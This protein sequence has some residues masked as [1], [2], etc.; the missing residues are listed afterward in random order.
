[1]DEE[2]ALYKKALEIYGI[3]SDVNVRDIKN[4]GFH[5]SDWYALGPVFTFD[6]K[7][8][9]YYL[10]NDYSLDDDPHCVENILNDI[11]HLLKGT[12]I[13]KSSATEQNG[14]YV[15]VI[16]GEEYYLWESPL[17]T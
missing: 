8:H 2:H 17:L 3:D 12:I 5:T 10:V 4:E 1:M 6:Y 13:K 14:M 7:N 15:E 11:N 16:D 9:H